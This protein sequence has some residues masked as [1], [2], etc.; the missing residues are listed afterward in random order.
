MG[1]SPSARFNEAA[2]RA[3]Y[4]E[5]SAS[6][7]EGMYASGF[8]HYISEGA[9]AGLVAPTHLTTSGVDYSGPEFLKSYEHSVRVNFRQLALLRGLL[10]K[11]Q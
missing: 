3:A 10:E 8:E 1:Y 11:T 5:V 9:L 7:A 6:I 4:P 2:Y